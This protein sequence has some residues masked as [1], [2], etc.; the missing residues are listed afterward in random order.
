MGQEQAQHVSLRG[1]AQGLREHA[2][3]W[4]RG[5][6]PLVLV[7]LRRSPAVRDG[8]REW[9]VRDVHDDGREALVIE[10]EDVARGSQPRHEPRG[11]DADLLRGIR[12][13]AVPQLQRG[14]DSAAMPRAAR[15]PSPA[16]ARPTP[17]LRQSGRPLPAPNGTPHPG[18]RLTGHCQATSR[19]RCTP[20]LLPCATPRPDTAR[21]TPPCM[22][23]GYSEYQPLIARASGA[24]VIRPQ[25]C[26]T[27][28]PRC[29]PAVADSSARRRWCG[30]WPSHQGT[31]APSRSGRLPAGSG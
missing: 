25:G 27:T 2:Q 21:L 31:V 9:R 1:D 16:D 15:V 4:R 8:T 5:A 12:M 19:P 3:R 18:S 6:V 28:A 24:R 7:S 17:P 23:R 20:T 11:Q 26:V 14:M 10:T 22:A 13:R 29:G 30:G